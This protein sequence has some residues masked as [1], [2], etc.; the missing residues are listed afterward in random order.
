ML[1]KHPADFRTRLCCKPVTSVVS[2]VTSA[3]GNLF[4]SPKM[5]ALPA[6]A[7]VATPAPVP[8]VDSATVAVQQQQQQ[9]QLQN[10]KKGAL[11]TLLNSG[12]TQTGAQLGARAPETTLKRFLG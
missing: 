12:N 7:T 5:P 3:V 11:S 9:E 6:P 1:G 10:Q 8:T 2:G 4:S